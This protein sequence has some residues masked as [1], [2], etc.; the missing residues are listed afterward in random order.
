[1]ISCKKILHYLAAGLLLASCTMN[2]NIYLN[3]SG[4]G[5]VSFNLETA[6]YLTDVL[7]ELQNLF[8]ADTPVAENGGLFDVP[9][10]RGDFEDREEVELL[11]LESP[12]PNRLEGEFEFRDMAAFFQAVPEDSPESNLISLETH[13]K[14]STVTI[15]ITRETVEALLQANPS[16]NNPL[17]ENFGPAASEGLSQDDYLDM[18][19]FALGS[20]SRQGLLDSALNL[21]VRVDGKITEQSGG[22][23][24]N[25][26]TV[27]YT[28][29]VLPLILLNDPIVYSLSYTTQ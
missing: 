17:L 22:T 1:M 19:E 10:I 21:T 26:S 11:H 12:A 23:L 5:R 8:P 24:V 4:G 7:T 15:R 13:G 2:Q 16:L 6:D 28:V 14:K 27:R 9:A 29:P 20:E 25:S 18:M 3:N